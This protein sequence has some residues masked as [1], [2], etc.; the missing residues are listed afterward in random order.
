[1]KIGDENAFPSNSFPNISPLVDIIENG[2]FVNL[3]IYPN[4]FSETIHLDLDQEQ[5]EV[6][7]LSVNGQEHARFLLSGSQTL[8][9]SGLGSGTYFLQL[10]SEKG[11]GM[12]KVIKY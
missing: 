2:Y 10:N 12:A 5:V 9:L 8:D 7:V 6:R 1:V 11:S 4:P 3:R